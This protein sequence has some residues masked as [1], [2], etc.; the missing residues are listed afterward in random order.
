MRTNRGSNS[1]VEIDGD[2][3]LLPSNQQEHS[4]LVLSQGFACSALFSAVVVV[5]SKACVSDHVGSVSVLYVASGSRWCLKI[6]DFSR[7][8]RFVAG[9]QEKSCVCVCVRARKW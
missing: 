5:G 6:A 7:C 9:R 8:R 2:G 1:S 4:M 3:R